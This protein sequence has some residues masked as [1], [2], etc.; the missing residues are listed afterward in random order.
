[1]IGNLQGMLDIS[2]LEKSYGTVRALNGVSLQV[3]SGEIVGFVGANGA[4]KSTT[5][6]IAMGLLAADAGRVRFREQ[7]LSFATRLRIGYMPESRGLYPKMRI[8]DQVAYFGQ[9]RGMTAHDARASAAGLI[10]QL[11]V[12]AEPN[13][14][15][16]TLSLGNQQR[17]QLAAALVHRP[18][19]LI[20]DEPFAGLDP[21]GVDTM[22]EVLGARRAAGVGVLFSSHQLDLVE[23]I[24][25]RIIIITSGRIVASGTLAELQ[26][27]AGRRDLELGIDNPDPDWLRDLPGV[28]VV[29][30][31]AGRLRLRLDRPGDD[32]AV[33][34]AAMRAGRVQHF[35]MASTPAVRAVSRG[36]PGM[37][38][39]RLIAG[40][41]ITTRW[42]QKGFRIGLAIAV[43]IVALGA[44]A[45][46]LIKGIGDNAITVGVSGT[47]A[48]ALASVVSQAASAQDLTVNVVVTSPEDAMSKVEKGAW[49]AAIVSDTKIIAKEGNSSAVALLQVIAQIRRHDRTANPSRTDEFAG[50][51]D[52]CGRAPSC[53]RHSVGGKHP[54]SSHCLRHRRIS[55][56][57]THRLLHLDGNGR[58]RGEIQ[59]SG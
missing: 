47:N 17:V 29:G 34:A 18:E 3:R 46:R 48:Q 54:A 49:D 37:T 22:A 31:V 58:R 32:Q 24:C 40:R 36:G 11:D 26:H 56:H 30:R 43:V 50:A 2:N 39:V 45:P 13:A 53:R 27:A 12:L 16:Q 5:M 38:T 4:G 6:R 57:A 20:L 44:L 8:V 42:Q 28:E 15:L 9:L 7:P 33:L 25:D 51:G 35:G 41:E 23:R 52:P 59:P 10:E 14:Q 19:L 21:V 1:M 55:V